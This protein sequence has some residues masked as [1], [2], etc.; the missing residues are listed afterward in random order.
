MHLNSNQKQSYVTTPLA[1]PEHTELRIPEQ[2]ELRRST[3]V[4]DGRK[5]ASRYDKANC[6]YNGHPRP[7][8]DNSKTTRR[9]RRFTTRC[10]SQGLVL[11][12][13]ENKFPDGTG[14]TCMCAQARARIKA[15]VP[16]AREA[17]YYFTNE[18]TPLDEQYDSK[19]RA[20][21]LF[22]P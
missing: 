22:P 15:G 11:N 9:H 17:N 13:P 14:D 1:F 10:S 19:Q 16:D 21:V 20:R 18:A 3:L 4:V 8:C 12:Q 2:T 7:A 5:R 6:C